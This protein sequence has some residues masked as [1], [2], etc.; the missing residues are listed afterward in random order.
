VPFVLDIVRHAEAE[1]GGAA[2]DAPRALS[3]GGRR[4]MAVLAETLAKESWRPDRIFSS[5]LLRARQTA[6]IL[7]GRAPGAPAIEGMEELL[8][9]A[10]P[11]DTLLALRQHGALAGHVVLVTHQPLAGRLVALLA[12]EASS[13][14]PGT[15]VRIEFAAEVVPGHGRV[16]RAIHPERA[17]R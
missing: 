5:P 7:R 16:M 9:D 13:F 1:A 17:D 4:A 15:L 8:P 10:E 12:A 6:E 3:D 11:S 14:K 2:G